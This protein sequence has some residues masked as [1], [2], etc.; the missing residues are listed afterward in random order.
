MDANR[1]ISARFR[2]P[3][4][5][6]KFEYFTEAEIYQSQMSWPEEDPDGDNVPNLLEYALGSSPRSP[7]VEALPVLETGQD[8]I[9]LV[10]RKNPNLAD[11]AWV[12]EVSEDL[13]IWS[14]LGDDLIRVEDGVEIRRATV[15]V[16]SIGQRFLRLKLSKLF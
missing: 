4:Q 9:S 12:V 11:V 8:T 7:G 5:R 16:S 10:Y 1:S 14:P 2:S 13:K 6:W 3:Y 15:P